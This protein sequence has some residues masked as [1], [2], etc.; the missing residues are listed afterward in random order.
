MDRYDHVVLFKPERIS[1]LPV[2]DLGHRLHFEIVVAG[3]ERAHLSPLPVLGAAGDIVR[4]SAFHAATLLDPL[5]VALLAPATRRCP[6][7]AP[8][9]HRIH[10]GIVE[11]DLSFAAYACGNLLGEGVRQ[12]L[13]NRKNVRHLEPGEHRPHAA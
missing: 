5:K 1:R 9:Q 13:L 10:L 6:G 4:P 2:D 3:T 12:F 8:R 11:R 7:S